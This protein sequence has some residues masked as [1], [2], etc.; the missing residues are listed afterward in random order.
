MRFLIFTAMLFLTLLLPLP[1]L[2]YY[3]II[4]QNG[5]VLQAEDCKVEGNR[6]S[7]RFKVGSASFPLSLV[8]SVTDQA[9]RESSFSSKGE[10][11]AP[12]SIVPA[13]KQS[14]PPQAVRQAPGPPPAALDPLT[15][16]GETSPGVDDSDQDEDEQDS[17]E[18]LDEESQDDEESSIPEG[19]TGLSH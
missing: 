12:A 11:Q 8:K 5:E 9:G 16:G 10:P 4:L 1:S 7:V 6:I 18:T 17:E 13:P 14:Q 2:A 19:P 3:N 15:R